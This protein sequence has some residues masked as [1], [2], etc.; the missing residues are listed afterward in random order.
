MLLVAFPFVWIGI[1]LTVRRLRDL[2]ASA[3]LSCLFFVPVLNLLFFL[4]LCLRPGR[5]YATSL[6]PAIV[7]ARHPREEA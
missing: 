3:W 1:A 5:G 7:L 4:L 6:P 2:G